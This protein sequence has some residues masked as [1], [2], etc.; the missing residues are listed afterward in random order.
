[1]SAIERPSKVHFNE[2]IV[3]HPF[4]DLGDWCMATLFSPAVSPD[5]V[6]EFLMR[7]LF[8]MKFGEHF[9]DLTALPKKEP[10]IESGVRAMT[11]Q[12]PTSKM[13]EVSETACYAVLWIER[14]LNR[15]SE[16]RWLEMPVKGERPRESESGLDVF[17]LE[18]SPKGAEHDRMVVGEVKST[19]EADEAKI[20]ARFK[21]LDAQ[22][23]KILK[24]F[25][26][27]NEVPEIL[28][29]RLNRFADQHFSNGVDKARVQKFWSKYEERDAGVSILSFLMFDS[30]W[31]EDSGKLTHVK[32]ALGKLEAL[33][34]EWGWNCE[35]NLLMIFPLEGFPESLDSLYALLDR[36][37]SEWLQILT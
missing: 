25:T 35:Q 13:R 37:K 17:Y 5:R 22:V 2:L 32:K 19:S 14:E 9:N 6:K 15:P 26:N 10:F 30:C 23:S 28:L 24:R 18:L 16:H 33:T 3:E 11:D 4:D 21:R 36:I 20:Q 34:K 29:Y 7:V 12:E 31:L 8:D 27:E 1:M